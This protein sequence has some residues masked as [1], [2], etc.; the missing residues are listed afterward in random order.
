MSGDTATIEASIASA[1]QVDPAILEYLVDGARRAGAESADALA[2]GG[3]S[4]AL[5]RRL[6]ARE[7][8]ERAEGADVGLRVLIGQRQA[9]VSSSDLSR[10][11]LDDLIERAVAMARH[12]PEDPYAGLA[13]PEQLAANFPTLDSVDPREPSVEL[14]D[15]RAAA[16]EDA[17]RAISGVSNS[18]GADASW[19]YSRVILAGSNGFFGTFEGS[20][21]S[22]SVAVLAGEGTHRELGSE[23]TTAVY[24]EDLRT[25]EEIGRRAGERAVARLNPRKISTRQVP[26]IFEQ[27]IAAGMVSAL[28]GAINGSSVARGTS[29]LQESMGEAVMAPGITIVDDPHLPRGLRSRPFDGEGIA[30]VRR[31]IV[32][33]GTL[34]SWIL[35]L[36]T[37]R[38]LGLETTGHASRGTTAAPTPAATN[39]FMQPGTVSPESLIGEIESGFY[40]DRLLGQGVNMVTGD[41]S[42]GAAGFWIEKGEIAYPVSEITIAGNLKDMFQAITPAN[43]LRMRRAL[44]APTLRIDGMTVAGT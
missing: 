29:F 19:G 28:A 8:I 32:S 31:E 10:Q 37:A 36:H 27:D 22:I 15:Q 21:H 7:E 33:G 13:A 4:I 38:Q 9:V 2:V 43:D 18:D 14:L 5:A 30:P 20:R 40:V 26:V 24:G 44:N 41:Y 17:A 3:I 25:P 6:G 11:A 1:P 42:R 39:L 23:F 16:A 35:D 12:V 34:N